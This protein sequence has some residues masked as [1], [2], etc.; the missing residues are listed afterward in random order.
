MLITQI[1]NPANVW[2]VATRS[3]TS[4]GG[5]ITFSQSDNASLAN[6]STAIFGGGA[7]ANAESTVVGSALANVTWNLGVVAVA[8]FRTGVTN[9]SGTLIF[10]SGVGGHNLGF[11][12]SN[13]G[14]VSGNY[15]VFSILW[16]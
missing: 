15:T 16:Q 10:G 14:T 11:A 9:A 5:A 2:T 4:L 6:G 8:T 3:L 7:A 12:L 1:T 13:T